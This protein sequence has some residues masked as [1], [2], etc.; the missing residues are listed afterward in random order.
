MTLAD[1]VAAAVE[2]RM[3][4]DHVGRSEALN[5]LVRAGLS[6]PSTRTRYE[7]KTYP[8][9]IKVDMTCTGEILALLDEL[10]AEDAAGRAG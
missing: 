7:H 10:D 2:A 9:G 4:G 1:D 5:D 3:R 6:A 8:L